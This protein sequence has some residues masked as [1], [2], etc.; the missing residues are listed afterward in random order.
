MATMRL[1][2]RSHPKGIIVFL[3]P[4]LWMG[5]LWSGFSI[6][7]TWAAEAIPIVV[8]PP[9]VAIITPPQATPMPSL[10]P[11]H[12]FPV[13]NG[14]IPLGDVGDR[15]EMNQLPPPPQSTV[16]SGPRFRVLVLDLRED[17]HPKQELLRSLVP[18]AFRSRYGDRPVLQVGSFQEQSK[19]QEL[20][21]FMEVNGFKAA[22]E[23]VL[24]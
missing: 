10:E 6:P 7:K 22:I 17:D 23:S 9:D 3:S 4:L 13:P 24:F 20:L 2:Q 15:P 21:Q 12:P 19:A 5:S 8:P 16:A 11:N 14:E 18:D 1:R